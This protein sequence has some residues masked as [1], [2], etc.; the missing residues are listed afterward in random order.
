MQENDMRF[1]K[2]RS[3]ASDET[4]YCLLRDTSITF[5]TVYRAV[6]LGGE[7]TAQKLRDDEFREM[8]VIALDH[9]DNL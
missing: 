3:R 1:W 6:R 4:T 8:L 2:V 9:M 5:R 7:K